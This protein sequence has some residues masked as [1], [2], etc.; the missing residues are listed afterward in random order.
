[1]FCINCGKQI[2]NQASFCQSCG[3]PVG[4]TIVQ[5]AILSNRSLISVGQLFSKTWAMFQ[6]V[7]L[8]VLVVTLL[9]I[10]VQ[11]VV[12]KI[13]FAVWGISFGASSLTTLG[14]GGG[15]FFLSN[16]LFNLAGLITIWTVF[17]VI[18]FW[19]QTAIIYVI[20]NQSKSDKTHVV[21]IALKQSWQAM[22]PISIISLLTSLL[23]GLGLI[24]LILPGLFLVFM[25][26][27]ATL[28]Y[29]IDGK[30]GV[31]AL[32]HSWKLVWSKFWGVA[33][34]N[35]LFGLLVIVVSVFFRQGTLALLKDLIIT[36]VWM[37]YSYLLYLD[38]SEKK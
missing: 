32:N 22:G 19:M 16:L 12:K 11:T 24:F 36:P 1:M 23:A 35:L 9:G 38:I 25:W 4:E 27:F 34:R 10:V 20:K 21:N 15:R 28:S 7:W 18:H 26:Q 6:S 30:K 2:L 37:I 33:G 8:T 14:L 31:D 13:V 3:K 17:L 5:S 29:I